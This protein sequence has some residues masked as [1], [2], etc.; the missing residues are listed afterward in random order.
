LFPSV[1]SI[2]GIPPLLQFTCI[3][4]VGEPIPKLINGEVLGPWYKRNGQ[5]ITGHNSYF[6]L[7]CSER[8]LRERPVVCILVVHNTCTRLRFCGAIARTMRNVRFCCKTLIPFKIRPDFGA[9]MA[10][11]YP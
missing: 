9:D 3:S 4:S 1:L 8:R 7:V 5:N 6:R 2:G 11:F 10:V